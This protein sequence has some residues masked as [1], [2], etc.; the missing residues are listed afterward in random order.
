MDRLWLPTLLELPAPVRREA[1]PLLVALLVYVANVRV[2]T[3]FILFF[4]ALRLVRP[5][6]L[7]TGKGVSVI[8]SFGVAEAQVRSLWRAN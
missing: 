3:V 4:F 1:G 5:S 2:A 6:I 8:A 7:G